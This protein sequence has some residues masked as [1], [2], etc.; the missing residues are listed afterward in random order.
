MEWGFFS[1]ENRIFVQGSNSATIILFKRYYKLAQFLIKAI[2]AT[3]VDPSIDKCG[4]YKKG[5]IVVVKDDLHIWGKKEGLPSFIVIS[6]TGL[7]TQ[8]V[9]YLTDQSTVQVRRRFCISEKDVDTAIAAGGL[10]ILTEQQFTTRL[11]NKVM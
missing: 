7:L 6:V 10:I 11:I 9:E 3:N 8:L 4:C 1:L 5:D 2:S